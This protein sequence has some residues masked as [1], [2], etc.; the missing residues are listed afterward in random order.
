MLIG[1]KHVSLSVGSTVLL[2]KVQFSL[3]ARERVCLMG[4]NGAGKSTLFRILN[5]QQATDSGEVV[6]ASDVRIGRMN[7]EIPTDQPGSVYDVVALGLGEIG[8]LVARFHHLAATAGND[9]TELGKV[10]ARIDALDGWVLESRIQS[11]ISRLKLPEDAVFSELSGGLKRRVLLGQALVAEPDILLLDEP[12]N[13]LDI[14]SIALLEE[15]L[16]QYQGALLFISHD[17]AFVRR[18]ATRVCDLDRGK[19][20]SWAGGYDAWVTGKADA[21]HAEERQNALFDKKL[22]EEEAWIRKGVEARR[23]RSAGR[24]KALLALRET[25]A[26]RRTREGEAKVIAQEAERSGKLVVEVTGITHRFGEQTVIRNFSA[27]VQRGEKIGLI[28]ENG[29][30]KSTLLQI[31]LGRLKPEAGEVRLG[32]KLELGYFD[33]MRTL[34]EE[35]TSVEAIGG[36]KEFVEINGVRK[37]VITYLQDFLFTPDRARVPV[38]VLSGGERARLLLARMFSKPSNVLVLDEPTNDL[39]LETLDLLEEQL[40]EY[41]GTVLL[42][43]HDREFLDNVVTRSLVFEGGGR[44][45]DYVGGYADWLRQRAL[46]SHVQPARAAP[47]PAAPTPSAAAPTAST[48]SRL[49]TKERRELEKL[50][51]R[52]EK[53]EAERNTLVAQ[54]GADEFYR[55]TR[56]Q[57]MAV[58]RR[59]ATIDQDLATAYARWEELEALR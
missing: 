20:S 14:P 57:Q 46:P 58:E 24:V 13:H 30:G 15:A 9:L 44:V 2:D 52:I 43:S 10:Q 21:L 29:A 23:T 42:V 51:A 6:R 53:L 34:V 49:D 17:R 33:Q 22:A 37:H 1:L 11:I 4:R 48:V 41:P 32:T 27:L 12:T 28:G 47:T 50:P 19:L 31:M 25:F 3:E 56:E 26:N 38:R 16:L 55:Q 8:A 39:D 40:I 36:G 18:L 7:Q 45:G 35:Q 5:G 59:I 54:M